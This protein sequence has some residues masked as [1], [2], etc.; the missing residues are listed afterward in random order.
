MSD[1]KSIGFVLKQHIKSYVQNHMLP[2]VYKKA[3]ART[4]VDKNKVIFAEMHSNTLPNSMMAVYDELKA[5]GKDITLYVR[6][7]KDMSWPESISFMKSFMKDYAA[8]GYVYICSYFLPVSSCKKRD[9]TKVIQLWHSGGLLK[10]MGYDTLDDIPKAYKG[11]V[12]ANY[13]LVTVSAPICVN[14]WKKALHLPAGITKPLGLPRTDIY[15]DK[16]WQAKCKARFEKIYP[17][18]KGKRVVLYAPSFSGNAASPKAPGLEMGLVKEFAKLDDV[19][20]IVRPHPLMRSVYPKYF[21]KRYKEI[22]TDKLLPAIDVLV[23]DYS[24][25]LFDYSVYKKPFVMFCPDIKEYER[26]RGFYAD[27]RSFPAPFVTKKDELLKCI[28]D[29][30]YLEKCTDEELEKFYQ[31]YMGSCDGKAT[32]R[33]IR[34]VERMK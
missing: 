18:A 13:D 11:N 20:L 31:I 32:K 27:P 21:D 3:V 8:A 15:F 22:S 12:T 10:K 5:S 23:T 34:E 16:K 7:I 29:K 24:S 4:K 25:I 6:D 33:L 1:M 9:E 2:K 26:S 14:Y 30:K 19:Y 28:E 17:E